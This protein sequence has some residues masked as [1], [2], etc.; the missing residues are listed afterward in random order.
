[1]KINESYE[2]EVIDINPDFSLKIQTDQGVENL[3][4]GEVSLKICK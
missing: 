2:A 4:T 1:M 3:F